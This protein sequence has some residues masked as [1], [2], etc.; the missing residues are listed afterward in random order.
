MVAVAKVGRAITI[1]IIKKEARNQCSKA[2]QKII[3]RDKEQKFCHHKVGWALEKMGHCY[4]LKC[5]GMIF[6]PSIKNMIY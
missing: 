4:I 2:L 5:E 3:Q 1:K 6:P